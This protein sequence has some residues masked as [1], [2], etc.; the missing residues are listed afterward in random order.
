MD[1]QSSLAGGELPKLVNQVRARTTPLELQFLRM[2]NVVASPKFL[3]RSVSE[4]RPLAPI[5]KHP[6]FNVPIAEEILARWPEW[7][8]PGITGLPDNSVMVVETNPEFV[9]ALL[10]G[11]N[12]EFNRELLW[13]EFPTDQRG[14]PFARF[15]PTAGNDVDEIARWPLESKLGSQVRGGEEGNIVLVIRG[16]VL[17]RFPA[18]PLVAVKGV[19]DKLPDEFTGIPATPLPLDESTMLYIFTGITETQAKDE[20]WFFVLREPMRGTQFGF[21]LPPEPP[22]QP[23]AMKTWADLTWADLTKTHGFVQVARDPTRRP[24]ANAGQALWGSESADMARIAFQ[25]PFQ[26]AFRARA[27]L[28]HEE[29]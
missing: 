25:Q 1:G 4:P 27:W 3:A 10:V 17:R 29:T 16:E 24:P 8:I 11:L 13:R 6:Q 15:W 9:A 19:G 20:D 14:T 22:A 28:S 12:Q 18:A 7:A 23:P 26:M 2:A 21:D 5:M